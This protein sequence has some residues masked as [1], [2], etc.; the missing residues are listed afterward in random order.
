[1]AHFA[2]ID[3]NNVVLRVLVVPDEQEH[4][5]QEYL[6]H[7]CNLGGTWVKTSYSARGSRKIDPHTNDF[8]EGVGFR[9]NFAGINFTYD[10][11]QDA[12]IPPKPNEGDWVLNKETC[13]WEQVVKPT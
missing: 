9:K 13:L 4:R 8:I 10:A 11:E 12:F 1:M 7:D 3:E 5:G 6:T 2:E